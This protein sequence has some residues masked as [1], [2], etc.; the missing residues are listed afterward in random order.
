MPAIETEVKKLRLEMLQGFQE[1]RKLICGKNIVG[2]WVA[3]NMACAMLGI[4]K[5]RIAQIRKHIDKDG[6]TAGSIRWRKSS[7]RKIEYYKPD[8]ELW[9][10][11][12]NVQ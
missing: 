11:K 6:K 1:I 3:Q 8:L 2:N 5:R 4:G 9:L 7:G 12:V 10:N